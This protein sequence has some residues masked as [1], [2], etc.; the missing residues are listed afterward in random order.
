MEDRYDALVLGGGAA[1]LSAALMLGRARRR[2]LVLDAGSP[3]N[4]FAAHMH[5][6]LGHDGID[7][8]ELLE[9]GRAEIAAYGVEVR[10]GDAV[11]IDPADAD[12]PLGDLVATLADGARIHARAV[13]LA[14]GVTDALPPIPG[15]AERWGVTVLHCPYCH[16]WEVR[17]RTIGVLATSPASLHQVELLRQWSDDVV[18]FVHAAG[19]LPQEALQRIRA[20][21]IRVVAAEVAEVVGAGTAIDHVRTVDGA[22]HPVDAIFTA[23]TLVPHDAA[24]AHLG[25]ARSEGPA[26]SVLAVDAMGMTS[27]P[28]ILAAGNVV[29]PFGNVPLAMGAG[30]MAGGG[31]NA[32]LVGVD[33]AEALAVQ[34]RDAE[35]RPDVAP[36]AYWEERYAARRHWSG[37]ANAALVDVVGPLEPGR[38]VDLGCGEGGDVVWLAQQ[39][40]HVT[41]VDIAPTAVARARQAAERAGVADRVDAVAAD[42]AT[43]EPGGEI[44][45][46][47]ASFLQS[48]VLLDRGA[49]VRA[50]AAHVAVGGRVLVV[51]HAATPSWAPASMHAGHHALPSPQEIVDE[52]ALGAAWAVDV[53]EVRTRAVTAPDGSDATLDDA[54]VLLRRIA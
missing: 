1:G 53:A 48:P 50:Q 11:R 44:D 12:A 16:G 25:L 40:W 54:V 6:V 35:P 46:V 23:A 39:G 47:T 52:L 27:H 49:I 36:A 15:L 20:R 3:R 32:M 42:L 21:G 24:V 9:R 43:W 31:A 5:G 33:A 34:A 14:T 29:V 38:A 2:T 19:E 7:P 10:S 26:G 41:G 28:R 22:K 18:A 13:V 30:S 37:H 4:R 17:D 8:A 45:L 51:A